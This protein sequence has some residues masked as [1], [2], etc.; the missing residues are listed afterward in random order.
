MQKQYH[1]CKTDKAESPTFSDLV[2]DQLKNKR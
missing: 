2:R 1:S